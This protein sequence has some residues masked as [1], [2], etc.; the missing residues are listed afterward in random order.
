MGLDDV[1]MVCKKA[2]AATIIA[3]HLDSV[4]HALVTSDD[5][6]AFSKKL[7]LDQV[8]VPFN[9]EYLEF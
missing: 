7:G 8:L 2:P 1:E 6:R 9:E 4:N 5:V 3:T